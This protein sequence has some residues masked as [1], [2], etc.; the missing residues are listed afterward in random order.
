MKALVSVAAIVAAFAL[1]GMAVRAQEAASAAV[2]DASA[3]FA[4]LSPDASGTVM[5]QIA[6][7]PAGDVLAVY[8]GHAPRQVYAKQD[9][10]F[11]VISGH[12]TASVGYPS[13]DVKPGS[14]ISV[15]RNTSFEITSDGVAP[16]KAILIASPSNDP[17]GKRVL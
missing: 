2:S 4:Q 14:V 10:L 6:H 5:Q 7:A 1:G 11:Y 12:G 8:I 16:I 17:A 15:P 13:F 9:E 3:A